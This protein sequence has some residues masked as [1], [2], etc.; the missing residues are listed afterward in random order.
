MRDVE[1]RDVDQEVKR[2]VDHY[3][4]CRRKMWRKD[5]DGMNINVMS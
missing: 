5:K 1:L 2:D 4:R 3:D